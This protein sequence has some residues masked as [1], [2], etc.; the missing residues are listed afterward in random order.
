MGN[1][2]RKMNPDVL[3]P[4][5]RLVATGQQRLPLLDQLR[6]LAICLML[7]FHTL[8]DIRTFY[9]QGEELVSWL[10][11]EF[12]RYFPRFVGGLFFLTLGAAHR[13]RR[14]R[15]HR[16][17]LYEALAPGLKLL[18]LGAMISAVTSLTFP[19]LT[20]Y[21][22]VLHCLGTT[23]LLLLSCSR[24]KQANAAIAFLLLAAGCWLNTVSIE[25]RWLLWLGVASSEGTGGDWYP[26]LPWAG[27]AFFG[28]YLADTVGDRLQSA[29]SS[30][31]QHL[32]APNLPSSRA[33]AWLGRHSL[34]VYLLHQPLLI[35]FIY[36]LSKWPMAS[37]S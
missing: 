7:S 27:V 37:P 5:P 10:P 29:K 3:R 35:S 1:S 17:A 25:S 8:Y 21:F 14:W 9:P 31:L 4:V 28:Y 18:F 15:Q 11:L 26:L 34:A 12:W 36:L 16:S 22:G 23:R 19:A 2:V 33:L 30:S 6:G 20:I 32:I 13:Q 24:W